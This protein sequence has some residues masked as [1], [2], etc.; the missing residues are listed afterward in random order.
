[1]EG[2]DFIFDEIN[3]FR[4]LHFFGTEDKKTTRLE[5]FYPAVKRIATRQS[6]YVPRPHF[7][8]QKSSR[9]WRTINPDVLGVK[10]ITSPFGIPLFGE[11]FSN[12]VSEFDTGQ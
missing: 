1:M 4:F 11:T 8:I 2:L 9:L 7:S 3:Y 10:G 12:I 6:P 5:Q